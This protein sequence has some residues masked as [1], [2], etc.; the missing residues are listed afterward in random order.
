MADILGGDRSI[1]YCYITSFYHETVLTSSDLPYKTAA[2]NR[3][4]DI[5]HK[6]DVTPA[7]KTA[8]L[9]HAINPML[10]LAFTR[11][12]KEASIVDA[13]YITKVHRVIWNHIEML[14]MANSIL[15]YRHH[16]VGEQRQEV[17]KFGWQFLSG[18]D[19]SGKDD[20]MVTNAAYILIARFFD[21]FDSPMKIV[22]QILL[23][24]LKLQTGEAK[25]LVC[26]ALDI[27]LPALPRRYKDNPTEWPEPFYNDR[28]MFVPA[29]MQRMAVSGS[30]NVETHAL[31]VDMVEVIIQWVQ[32]RAEALL[33]KDEDTRMA[34]PTS[35][36]KAATTPALRPHS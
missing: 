22:S 36:S 5:L 6:G 10:L 25:H 16:L 11:G 28:D 33:V 1:K 34:D 24:L 18:K 8:I 2:A 17:I 3:F 29:A 30:A 15:E 32:Q 4:L 20:Q 9:R 14:Q 7:H 26:K 35:I 23:G 13:E 31:V 12:K 19:V 21:A 27:L